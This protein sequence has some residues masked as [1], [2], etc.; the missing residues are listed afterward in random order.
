M[1]N[2]KREKEEQLA[3]ANMLSKIILS[4]SNINDVA[5]GFAKELKRFMS[6]DWAAIAWIEKGDSVCL[7]L[8]LGKISL[9][10]DFASTLP[11]ERTPIAWL[12]ENKRALLEP[13]LSKASQ[14]WTVSFLGKLEKQETRSMVLMPLFSGGEVFGSLIVGSRKPNAYGERELRLLKYAASQLALPLANSLLL[15]KEQRQALIYDLVQHFK[16]GEGFEIFAQELK[17]Q[18]LFD[19]CSITL[20][21]GGRARI[22]SL[23]STAKTEL[24]PGYTFPLEDTAVGW[25]VKNKRSNIESDFSQERHFPIDEIHLKEGMRSEIRVPI[26]SEAEVFATLHLA[27]SQPGTYKERERD[28]LEEL[29][30]QLAPV[31]ESLRSRVVELEEGDWLSTLVQDLKGPL[32]P[33]I[34]S[35]GL[36][37]EQLQTDPES[38]EA[39]LS[40]NV[41]RGAQELQNKLSKLL[42]AGRRRQDS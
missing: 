39:K 37:A 1:A 29:A 2:I 30:S 9:T 33:V 25:V 35:S 24:S 12:A 4:S 27:S 31:L 21:E 11:V 19:S 40:Q 17:K 15:Q 42:S 7:L 34:A 28:F 26:F 14:P 5:E 16:P 23:S 41:Y 38:A 6:I 22:L 32:T 18:V 36:L 8:L 10:R 20:V 3:L 13:D